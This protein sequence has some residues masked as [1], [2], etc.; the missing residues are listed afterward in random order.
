MKKKIGKEIGNKKANR[1]AQLPTKK[2]G[3]DQSAE[4]AGSRWRSR[5]VK[6]I[7][8]EVLVI[9]V[10][11]CYC[12]HF[13]LSRVISLNELPN[14]R[15]AKTVLLSSTLCQQTGPHFQSTVNV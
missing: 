4:G 10:V 6:K 13:V 7:C 11:V 3:I 2:S 1:Y 12:L 8:A 9:I 14:I 5:F 15:F